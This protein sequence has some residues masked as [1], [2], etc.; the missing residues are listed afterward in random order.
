MDTSI[1]SLVGVDRLQPPL[2]PGH[3]VPHYSPPPALPPSSMEASQNAVEPL[4]QNTSTTAPDRPLDGVPPPQPEVDAVTGQ[5]APGAADAMDTSVDDTQTR[6]TSTVPAPEEPPSDADPP[7]TP[8]ESPV[9]E[10]AD[11]SQ[12]DEPPVDPSI[13]PPPPVELEH[14]FW[15][16]IEEDLSTPDEAELKEIES[17]PDGDYSAYEYDYWEKS[18]YRDVEDPEHRPSEKAR[19]TWKF[20]GVRGTKD[21]PNRAKIMRSPAAYVGGYWWTLKFFP[22]GNSVGALSVY[23][24]CSPD[25]PSP[26]KEL[27][28]TEFKVLRGP[29]DAVLSDLKPDMEIKFPR[30]EDS[31][32]WFED[33]K[34][35][36]AVPKEA[37]AEQTSG[38]KRDW[39]VSAQIGVILYNPE[40]PRTGWMQSSCHQFNRHNLDWGWTNFHGPWDQIHRRQRGQRQALLRNDT[41]AFDAYIR[42]F[43]DPTQAL[44]WHSSDSEPVWDSLTLTGYRPMGDSVITH[45]AEVA[46][47]ASWLLMAPVRQ[48]IQSVDVLEHLRN[49]DVKPK[50]L[51]DALQKF[52]WRMRNQSWTLPSVDT[53]SVTRTLRNLQEHSEDVIQ[54]WERLRRGLELELAGTE[55][56]K[57]LAKLFDSQPVAAEPSAV[58][59][60]LPSEFNSRIQVPADTAKTVQAAVN[61]YLGAKPGRW[62]LPP[63]LHVELS[64]QRFDKSTR[65][66]KLLYDRVDLDEVLDLTASVVDGQCGKYDLY[67]FVVHRGSRASADFFSILRPGGPGTRWLAFDDGSDNRIE[68]L[69]RK[70]ALGA[71]VGP[72]STKIPDDKTGHDLAVVVLYVRSDVVRDFLPGPPE[73][74][75][76]PASMKVYF[77]TGWYPLDPPGATTRDTNVNV[78]IYS[79][80]KFENLDSLFDSYDLMSRAKSTKDVMCLTV[81]YTTTVVDLRKKIARWKST[82][83]Q[84]VRPEHVRLWQ[85]GQ[86]KDLCGPTLSFNRITDLDYTLE[87][88]LKTV[89]FWIH[90]VSDSDAKYFAMADPPLEVETVDNKTD[91]VQEQ[92]DSESSDDRESS[93]GVHLTPDSTETPRATDAHNAD[94]PMSE[95][96]QAE[97]DGPANRPEAPAE[98]RPVQT[99]PADASR[100]PDVA[101]T[102]ADHIAAVADVIASD[103]QEMDAPVAPP[104]PAA[105]AG[106]T[107][108]SVMGDS[109]ANSQIPD[110]ESTASGSSTPAPEFT[111]PVPHVYY[112]IQIFDVDQQE[113]RTVGSYFSR[114]ED[115][116]K[117]AI[118]KYLEWPDEKDFQIWQRVDGT[119][120][121]AVS[122]M[123]TFD[124]Y[125]PDGSCFIVGEQLTH[126]RRVEL[127]RAGL[128]TTPDRL[129]E[130]LWASSRKHPTKAFTGTRTLDAAFG[131]D[132]YSGEFNKGYY[133]GKGTHISESGATYVGD[134][135]FGLRHGKGRMEYSSGDTYDGD[136]MEDERHGQ[137]TFVERKT[138]NKYVGGYRQGKR[139]GKGISYWEV[140]DEEMDL[141]QI[142]YGED[143]DAL[144][145]DCGHV[146]AC[147]GCARQVDICP[148]CRKNVIS[149]VKIYKT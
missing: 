10:P 98:Q 45:C 145:Y 138:G 66:W 124:I 104:P 73:P 43:D 127:T 122:S 109:P 107:N 79:L 42:I 111:S 63:V 7:E 50:P 94:S 13:P 28:E 133:H 37:S 67:G 108:D 70:A 136:W 115:N 12:G 146:C 53:D 76:V 48:I 27:P 131:G 78:E 57:E 91:A 139:H 142:C 11:E 23:I 134:F 83:S 99:G 87:F 71:H 49:C 65:Q 129:V 125:V 96:E 114:K 130:Y 126:D 51:C 148:I 62:S 113:L 120:V 15:A 90:I 40:E 5:P 97:S 149:V 54:F 106:Q 84:K 41:L 36:Y 47:L 38:S 93:A 72:D 89:R 110:G 39:R 58:V 105:S 85:I 140:A 8:P 33:Y 80:A 32:Q 34:S 6:S 26:D 19:L 74:W 17:A 25:M 14:A 64:R 137:G 116:I 128:F 20:K 18:F 21:R 92:D 141:C 60:Y 16:D 68:C 55:A 2:S 123:D 9:I 117:S 86:T 61:R 77:E 118:R 22:R 1:D 143:Q 81:P 132:Y 56:G 88:N 135:V 30:V 95:P 147:V 144:F 52:L 3:S 100:Q 121:T 103:M 24:E 44:W 82:T 59:N 112:F 119:I 102:E 75:E 46:G 4:Q 29:P 69:T 35:R 101:M 31:T